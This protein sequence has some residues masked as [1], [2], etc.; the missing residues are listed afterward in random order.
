MEGGSLDPQ[1]PA[2]CTPYGGTCE[3]GTIKGQELRRV[4]DDCGECDAG[5]HMVGIKCIAWEGT[6]ENGLLRAQEKRTA[7]N[8]CGSCG[9]G[10]KLVGTICKAFG[11]TCENGK[12]VPLIERT[13]EDQCGSCNPGYHLLA[14]LPG[15]GNSEDPNGQGTPTCPGWAGDCENGSLLEQEDRRQEDHCGACDA[16]YYLTSVTCTAFT[17]LCQYGANPAA[18]S[19]W[20]QDYDCASCD[21]GYHIT[22]EFTCVAW[23][24]VCESGEI[25]SQ[26]FRRAEN[27]CLVCNPGYATIP[28]TGPALPA[29]VP[30]Q[31]L[32]ASSGRRLI[33]GRRLQASPAW[34]TAAKGGCQSKEHGA[35]VA[36]EF[37]PGSS[38]STRQDGG[39]RKMK[40]KSDGADACKEVCEQ[41]GD[42]CAG[43]LRVM[44]ICYFVS[45]ADG[46]EAAPAGAANTCMVKPAAAPAAPAAGHGLTGAELAAL[47]LS[48]ALTPDGGTAIVCREWA[49]VCAN[50]ALVPLAERLSDDHCGRC[51]AGY[52]LVVPDGGIP[53]CDPWAGEC[54]NGV[55]LPQQERT[56]PDHCAS[57][58]PGYNQEPAIKNTVTCT[59]MVDDYLKAVF[60]DGTLLTV[61]GDANS[62]TTAKAIT[63][64]GANAYL[65][66]SAQ[67]AS[68]YPA[69]N[70]CMQSGVSVSC[71]STDASSPWHGFS[72]DSVGLW[73]AASAVG[74][75]DARTWPSSSAPKDWTADPAATGYAAP[76]TT[77][78]S[79]SGCQPDAAYIWADAGDNNVWLIGKPVYDDSAFV[80]ADICRAWAGVCEHGELYV[81]EQRQRDDDCGTCD[82]GYRLV[83][84]SCVAWAGQCAHGD[85][86]PQ[87]QR[88]QGDHCGTCDAGYHLVGVE[89]IAWEGVCRHGEL[90]IL[91]ERTQENDCGVCNAGYY[92][93]GFV[94]VPYAGVC[95]HGSLFE[96]ENRLM[97]GSCGGC[98]AGYYRKTARSTTSARAATLA[99][100]STGSPALR[101]LAS[102]STAS[103]ASSPFARPTTTAASATATTT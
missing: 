2:T 15:A 30:V 80:P 27:D 46:S 84:H 79:C 16:G 17:G 103:C 24:G 75:G 71:T 67:E 90:K 14:G 54:T 64:D 60:F 83:G 53:R 57:C 42:K 98:D 72:T 63:F 85:L 33:E 9:A 65:A 74:T 70:G 10:Y 69:T 8:Q 48:V 93:S 38:S 18:Q 49:G 81:Q 73:K 40:D 12:L 13:M 37:A 87:E 11:G 22:A 88:E 6:C 82:A 32:V 96:Q 25:R 99:T 21:D 19:D 61:E 44:S 100:T 26:S 92:L 50:G 77:T 59:L 62:A 43:F 58:N 23:G 41:A 95:A 1:A 28:A 101:T 45:E 89:C 34:T 97:D 68:M 51:N 31:P 29:P 5:Y 56:Q 66:V 4:E 47:E 3:H 102:A 76:C 7:D 78:T 91:P 86:L 94:C 55:L 39:S 20:T 36:P 35:F 52:H